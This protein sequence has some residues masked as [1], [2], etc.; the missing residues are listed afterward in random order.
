MKPRKSLALEAS[1]KNFAQQHVISYIEGHELT[2]V[3]DVVKWIADSI[4]RRKLWHNE[5]SWGLVVDDTKVE[6]RRKHDIQ[7]PA[8]G[9]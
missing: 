2:V 5:P 8:N 4:I 6:R 9:A 3:H 7:S 1:R